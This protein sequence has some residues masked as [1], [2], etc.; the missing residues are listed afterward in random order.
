MT[1]VIAKTKDSDNGGSIADVVKTL[2]AE[3]SPGSLLNAA[4]HALSRE[5]LADAVLH[6]IADR[7]FA[8]SRDTAERMAAELIEA[9]A[10][11]V[12]Y[13]APSPI[14]NPPEPLPTTDV[15]DLMAAISDTWDVNFR[16][17]CM[18][19][20]DAIRCSLRH[21]QHAGPDGG[22]VWSNTA[23]AIK[24]VMLIRWPEAAALWFGEKS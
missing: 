20:E 17:A 19:H 21:Y 3:E 8:A 6:N 1:S 23:S 22:L 5:P 18:G 13:G 2:V 16:D 24:H 15:T 4:P 14:G 7:G 9:R 12:G 10:K 11:L